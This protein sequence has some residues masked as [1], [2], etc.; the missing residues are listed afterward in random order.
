MIKLG[1][2]GTG[3]ISDQFIEA[4]A[5]TGMYQLTTVYSRTLQKAEEFGKNIWLTVSILTIWK[6]FLPKE[7]L[8][9]FISHHRTVFILRNP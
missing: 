6:N 1:I 3:W 9:R 5:K 2:I 4:C 7:A 8:T